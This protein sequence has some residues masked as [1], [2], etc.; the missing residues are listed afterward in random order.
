MGTVQ[1]MNLGSTVIISLILC[2]ITKNKAEEI[3]NDHEGLAKR[4]S[5]N[6]V[7]TMSN[8]GMDKRRYS[9]S[10]WS[11][12]NLKGGGNHY[13]LESFMKPTSSKSKRFSMNFLDTLD[14]A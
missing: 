8:K 11:P 1:E 10:F 13:S 14:N 5:M 6:Y 2:F 3:L 4:F 9:A 7:D 12:S